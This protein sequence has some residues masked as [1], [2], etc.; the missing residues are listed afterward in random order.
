MSSSVLG[1]LNP[2]A[3]DCNLSVVEK[4]EKGFEILK[5]PTGKDVIRHARILSRQPEAP[6]F[7]G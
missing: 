1:K 7:F 4:A 3:N 5:T 2:D 6:L